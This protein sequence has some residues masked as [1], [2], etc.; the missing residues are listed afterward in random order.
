MGYAWLF[1]YLLY[2]TYSWSYLSQQLL[3]L[4]SFFV[5]LSD[6]LKDN[7][8]NLRSKEHN[9]FSVFG[10]WLPRALKEI[11]EAHASRHFEEKPIGPLGEWWY[12]KSVSSRGCI[13]NVM[14]LLSKEASMLMSY[15]RLY[16]KRSLPLSS[17][18]FVLRK[19]RS[20]WAFNTFSQFIFFTF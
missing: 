6:Q 8:R 16:S 7:I 20:G 5:S 11:D 17:L 19:Y 1:S 10:A 12:P 9:K 4:R 14:D 15:P 2:T 18:A 13:W 3:K